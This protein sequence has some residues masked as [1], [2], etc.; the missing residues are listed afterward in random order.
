METIAL[1]PAPNFS[2][3][4]QNGNVPSKKKHTT[5]ENLRYEIYVPN[6][7]VG[8]LIY[9]S[10]YT[11]NSSV[12]LLARFGVQ[13]V[14]G[15]PFQGFAEYRSP[16]AT[17]CATVGGKMYKNIGRILC[18]ITRK[19]WGDTIAYTSRTPICSEKNPKIF[20]QILGKL[21]VR[22]FG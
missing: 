11:S 1:S 20:A 7:H 13:R 17:L 16:P 8:V 2:T 18:A 19:N 10:V 21:R 12:Y 22:Q 9:R 3:S 14:V 6:G 4:V 15:L 5:A